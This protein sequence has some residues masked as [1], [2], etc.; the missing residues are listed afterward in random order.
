MKEHN[1]NE[2][3]IAKE[4]M[5]VIEVSIKQEIKERIYETDEHISATKSDLQGKIPRL[6]CYDS[7]AESL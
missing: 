2:F 3:Q 5:D 6:K 4:R 1:R 7:S